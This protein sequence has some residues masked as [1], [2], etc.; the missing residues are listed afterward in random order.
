[1]GKLSPNSDHKFCPYCGGMNERYLSIKQAAR[2]TDMSVE[3]WRKWIKERS[4]DYVK[5]GGSIRIAYSTFKSMITS[6]PAI[7]SETIDEL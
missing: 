3:T 6:I 4:I 2:L 1:M 7:N 5:I